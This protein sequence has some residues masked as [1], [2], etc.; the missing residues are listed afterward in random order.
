MSFLNIRGVTCAIAHDEGS[1][2]ITRTCGEYGPEVQVRF[3]T[4]WGSWPNLASALM[5]SSRIDDAGN[6]VRVPP[7]NLPW[8]PKLFCVG[9]GDEQPQT[10]RP[11]TSGWMYFETSIVTATF[12]AL[13]Y[14]IEAGDPEGQ[15]D[16]SGLPY[17]I[18]KFRV[19][20][21]VYSPPEGA[22]Y[23]GPFTGS[24]KL[25]QPG[26]VGFIKPQVEISMLRIM[27][28]RIPLSEVTALY[29]HVNDATIK[30]GNKTFPIGCL[31][32]T[33]F[34]T[35]PRNDPD[36]RPVYDL[37]YTFLGHDT[38]EFNQ[39]QVESGVYEYVNTA[40]DESGD[41]PFPYSDLN[42]LFTDYDPE[43]TFI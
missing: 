32:F 5:G 40:A 18:T 31:L 12:A 36:G 25:M 15:N 6:V 38:Q 33:G 27:M 20:G 29:G 30:I 28:P 39:V 14:Q 23:V 3:K 19:N 1:P 2:G 10:P 9:L 37:E 8:A 42:F 21:E 13:P 26:T 11:D 4:D 35:D 43:P 41:Y 16:P 17:T 24:A 7:Y 34:N 22:Y